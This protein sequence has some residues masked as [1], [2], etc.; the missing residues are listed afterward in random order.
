MEHQI[1]ALPIFC[2]RVFDIACALDENLKKLNYDDVYTD[3]IVI[4][5]ETIT[6]R[7]M[8]QVEFDA[9]Y[10]AGTG[11]IIPTYMVTKR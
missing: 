2:P 3:I 6:Y 7:I 11:L 1:T 4:D 10:Y 9:E 8:T 5:H